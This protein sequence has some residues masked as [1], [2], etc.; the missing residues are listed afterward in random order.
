MHTS[1]SRSTPTVVP[2]RPIL[3]AM[4]SAQSVLL[5]VAAALLCQRHTAAISLGKM[6][7]L[8]DAIHT[9]VS[10]AVK[11]HCTRDEQVCADESHTAANIG[12]SWSDIS[13]FILSLHIAAKGCCVVYLL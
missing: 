5:A 6:D 12:N 2:S 8:K 10:D 3:V 13:F 1:R 11:S 9:A 7:S 4:R